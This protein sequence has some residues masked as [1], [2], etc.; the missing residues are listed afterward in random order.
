MTIPC[1]NIAEL[2]L[3]IGEYLLNDRP[4][5]LDEM[6]NAQD[7]IGSLVSTCREIVQ[8]S[9]LRRLTPVENLRFQNLSKIL[10]AVG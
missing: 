9:R 10:G 6:R 7:L 1:N 8:T 5:N 3:R 4:L 2:Q